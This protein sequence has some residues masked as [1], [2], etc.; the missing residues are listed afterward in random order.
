MR[1]SIF[2][3]AVALAGCKTVAKGERFEEKLAEAFKERG[4]TVAVSCPDAIPLGHVSENRFECD[5]VSND[6][7]TATVAVQLDT[8]GQWRL[9]VLRETPP[10]RSPDSQ[11]ADTDGDPWN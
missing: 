6:G 10:T 11:V 7:A 2:V 5:L 3:L 4:H 1:P 8:A 9:D